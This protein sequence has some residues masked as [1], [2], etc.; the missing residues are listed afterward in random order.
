M[1]FQTYRNLSPR[2]R[3]GVGIA[4]TL[5]GLIGLKLSDKAEEKLGYTP[6]EE[7]RKALERF[8]PRIIEV[9]K[10]VEKVIGSEK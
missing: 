8:K 9:E 10:E 3:L 6:T 5:W 4:F 1:V 2:A 7:D